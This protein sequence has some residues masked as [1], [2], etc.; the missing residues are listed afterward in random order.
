M[1]GRIAGITIEIGGDTTNLQKSLK[2]V[3]SALKTTQSNLK[4]IN[5]LLKLDPSNVELLRQKQAA[6]NQAVTLTKDRLEELKAAQAGVKEG[7]AEWDALQREIIATEQELQRLTKEQRAFGNV[8]GQVLKAAG[9]KVKEF[10]SKV[11]E[12]GRKLSGI[13]G[14]AGAIGGALL[15]MGYDSV[16]SADDLN[17][18]SKQTG[19]ATDELQKMQYASD[20]VDVSVE[21]ITGALKKM[22]T[23][24]TPTN[25]AFKSLGVEVANADGSLRSAN[26]VFY[27]TLSALSGIDNEV[28]RDQ[29]AMSIFGKSADEL[30]GIIDDGGESLKAFGQ[31]AEDLGLILDQE[32]LDALNDTNDTLDSLKANLKGTAATIGSNVASVVAPVL[33]K[34]A[35]AIAGITERLREL[36]P[37]QTETIMK[38]VGVVAAVAPALIIIGKLI[39]GI[40]SIV[41]V[42]GSVVGFLGGPLTLAIG[43]AIAVGVLLWKNWDKIKEV[44]ANLWSGMK[45]GWEKVKSGVTSVVDTIKTATKERWENIKTTFTEAGGGIQGA[46]AVYW[47][48]VKSIWTAGFNA[49]DSLTNGKLS[50]IRDKF[51][52]IFDNV[53]NTVRNALNK[54]KNFVANLKLQLPHIKLPHFKVSGGEPPYGLGGKGSLPKIEIDW[55]KAAYENPVIFTQP[56]ILQTPQGY[57]G[58]GDGNGAE[59]VM[60]LDRLRE[61]VGTKNNAPQAVNVTVV[62]EGDAKGIFRVVKAQNTTLTRATNY[63]ALAVGG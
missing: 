44:A 17:T 5:K 21:S 36:S 4:D 18:L 60:G 14:A 61:L 43:A 27:D 40:G 25:E 33:E 41:T 24:M 31:E 29:A 37:E 12:A 62:L 57:K 7:T 23:N 56:T 46:V 32:T 16:K 6:L 35:T 39:S 59:I 22:K 48:S 1:A 3:D 10:G 20:R 51:K 42:L 50:Q 34:I 58:F 2:S 54:I 53:V 45:A 38:I 11:E 26:D 15:K 47:E 28:E 19:I 55:Y 30:A 63:N 13:S 8:A 49:V 9:Q 52:S